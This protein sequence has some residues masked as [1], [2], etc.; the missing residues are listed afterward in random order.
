MLDTSD[1]AE[2]NLCGGGFNA[3]YT[4]F[5]TYCVHLRAN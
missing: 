4:R 3:Y 1:P 5:L 2:T